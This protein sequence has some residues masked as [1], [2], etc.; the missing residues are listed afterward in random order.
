MSIT[1]GTM[2]DLPPKPWKFKYFPQGTER[3]RIVIR[4]HVWRITGPALGAN[5]HHHV[6]VKEERNYIWHPDHD[7]WWQPHEAIYGDW[8]REQYQ[9]MFAGR[10]TRSDDFLRQESIRKWVE[11]LFAD[12]GI[13]EESHVIE[14]D[15][16]EDDPLAISALGEALKKRAREQD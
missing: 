6:T 10:E 7:D 12:W 16:D 11:A 13:T 14:W 2:K 3:R 8:G 9:E 4:S 1:S 15:L 5:G